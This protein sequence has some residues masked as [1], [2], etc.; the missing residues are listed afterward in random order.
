MG[1]Q[2]ILHPSSSFLANSFPLAFSFSF[3]N[4]SRELATSQNGYKFAS[5]ISLW[6]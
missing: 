1:K 3:D 2:H 5:L 4:F 6:L